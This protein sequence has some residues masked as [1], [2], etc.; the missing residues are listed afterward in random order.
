M[1]LVRVEWPRIRL[2][3][4]RRGSSALSLGP[5]GLSSSSS[6]SA[7]ASDLCSRVIVHVQTWATRND[8]G[9]VAPLFV[10]SDRREIG[11]VLL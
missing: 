3:S 5:L 7:R 4:R 8:E 11:G 2:Y 1:T 6:L 10:Q 9:S